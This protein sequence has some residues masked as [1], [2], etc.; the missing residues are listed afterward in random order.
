MRDGTEHK[1]EVRSGQL[2]LDDKGMTVSDIPQLKPYGIR[3][4][5]K[6]FAGVGASGGEVGIGAEVFHYFK[7]NVDV[8][9]TQK[10]AYVG[11]SWDVRLGSLIEN[12]SVGI[13]FGKAWKDPDD[14]RILVYWSIAF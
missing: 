12:S 10:A 14:S 7:W 6:L 1:V 9:G 5:P 13:S 2:F 8:S 3:I 11:V 4:R